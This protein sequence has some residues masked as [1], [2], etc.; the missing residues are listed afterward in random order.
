MEAKQRRLEK[1]EALINVTMDGRFE[2][3]L[4]LMARTFLEYAQI[5]ATEEGRE[6]LI[7]I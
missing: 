7:G 3:A 4:E 2:P 5:Q 6:F 1:G